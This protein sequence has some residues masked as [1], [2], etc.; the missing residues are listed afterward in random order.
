M[1]TQYQRRQAKERRIAATYPSEQARTIIEAQR[2]AHSAYG[3]GCAAG[4][5]LADRLRSLPDWPEI[6][7]DMRTMVEATRD[8][9]RALQTMKALQR[10]PITA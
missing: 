3:N 5:R 1:A 6:L 10:Q 9:E 8:E 7:A 4:G 2:T